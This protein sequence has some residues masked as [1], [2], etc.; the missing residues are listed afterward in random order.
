M[1]NWAS[2]TLFAAACLMSCSRENK[3]T[4]A[5]EKPSAPSGLVLYSWKEYF[6]EEVLEDFRKATGIT[7]DYQTFGEAEEVEARVDERLLLRHRGGGVVVG[8]RV[9]DPAPEDVAV[10]VDDHRLR[11]RRAEINSDEAA[12]RRSP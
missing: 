7:V 3:Q 12:H 9:G 8:A 11:G 6:S 1:K 5:T 4:V 2:I 10:L